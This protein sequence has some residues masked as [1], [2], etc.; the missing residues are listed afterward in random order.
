LAVFLVVAGFVEPLQ[1]LFHVGPAFLDRFNVVEVD[2][3]LVE[4]G[5]TAPWAFPPLSLCYSVELATWCKAVT[6]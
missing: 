1:V 3:F 4:Q 2:G 6:P 5:L